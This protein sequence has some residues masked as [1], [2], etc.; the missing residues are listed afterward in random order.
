MGSQQPA[1]RSSCYPTF[2]NRPCCR[3]LLLPA[4]PFIP[5]VKAKPPRGSCKNRFACLYYVCCRGGFRQKEKRIN[6]LG[7]RTDAR[8][9]T[10]LDV[11]QG[12]WS[13]LVIFEAFFV[14]F[15]LYFGFFFC[16]FF[17]FENKPARA[18]R[19][20]FLE[21]ASSRPVWSKKTD[22]SPCLAAVENWQFE[23]SARHSLSWCAV[24]NA[25]WRPNLIPH[26]TSGISTLS[27]C[28]IM[29]F[30]G[31]MVDYSPCLSI[32]WQYS[33]TVSL[34]S[35]CAVEIRVELKACEE[36]WRSQIHHVSFQ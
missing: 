22:F 23:V 35:W 2:N 1:N 26:F 7:T 25:A 14:K 16:F 18:V 4:E 10:H 6:E 33:I 17:F 15:S 36:L 24:V 11:S 31:K 5:S 12:F 21:P 28:T 13:G 3:W 8:A 34:F 29:D 30:M 9:I 19:Q 27:A 32:M 20:C